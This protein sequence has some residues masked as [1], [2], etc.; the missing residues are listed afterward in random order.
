MSN[1]NKT[2]DYERPNPDDLIERIKLEDSVS[3]RGRLVIFF[4]YAAGVG[5][6]YKMLEAA[7]AQK[8]AGID[9]VI[10]FV[11][12]HGRI[13]T[14]TLMSSLECLPTSKIEYRSIQIDEFDIDAALQR[15]PKLI[16]VDE[17]AHTNTPECR[18][19][20]RWQDIEDLRDSGIDVFTTL[21]VQH[22][23][24]LNDVVAQ[25]TGVIV[26]E[27]I[28]DAVFDSADEI[29]LIDLP[30]DELLDRLKHGKV[31]LPKQI[32]RALSNFFI[33]PNLIA[34]RELA[35]RKT[36]ERINQQVQTARKSMGSEKI[37]QTGE[38]LLVCVSPN[39]LSPKVIR[40]AKRIATSLQTN[41]I[42]AHVETPHSQRISD[43]SRQ[44]LLKHLH[45][46]E[47][48]GAEIV[49][50]SGN[51]RADE[52]L[53]YAHHRNI[54]QIIVGYSDRPWWKQFFREAIS[55]ELQR[56]STDIDVLVVVGTTEKVDAADSPL[57]DVKE[58]KGYKRSLA[59]V[60]LCT[61]IAYLMHYFQLAEANKVMV[62]LLGVVFIAARYGAGPGILA[63]IVS[64]LLFD[65]LMVK[66]F[67]SF[68]V[69]D[70][71]YILTFLV[72][73][74]IAILISTLTSRIAQQSDMLRRR[75]QRTEA[76]Y[77]LSRQLASTAG[78]H[79][80]IEVADKELSEMF[81]SQIV[82][83]VR[84]GANDFTPV[85]QDSDYFTT[86][87]IEH[88]VAMWAFT[89][90]Q[91][92]GRGTDT[93]PQAKT[94][95]LPLVGTRGALGVLG[96]RPRKSNVI[97][98]PEQ[99][100]T[101]ETLSG[102]IALA[103]ERELFSDQVQKGLLDIESERLRSS[104]LSSISHDLRTPLSVISGEIQNLLGRTDLTGDHDVL[105]SLSTAAGE[106][107][108]L[109]RYIDNLLMI[110]R[111][112]A[113]SIVP[114]L[115][116]NVID[117]VIGSAISA[118]KVDLSGKEIKLNVPETP[119]VKMDSVLIERV[120]INLLDNAIKFSAPDTEIE[121]EVNSSSDMLQ[122][123]ISDRGIGM[124][125]GMEDKIFEKFYRSD[126][127]NHN[128]KL[129]T[130]LGLSIC[131]SI[132][133]MHNGSITATNRDGG[134]TIVSFRLPLTSNTE[135]TKRIND[136]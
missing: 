9:V 31:Y 13:E 113:G 7:R 111:L 96:L 134:G 95:Y 5:K 30:P 32:E 84:K 4:G 53:D 132:L 47:T 20:K 17:L 127:D 109:N 77:R 66:P 21:N 110:T 64:V 128:R 78:F 98:M 81:D 102:Q 26:Q 18:H 133:I 2:I 42:A 68:A 120:L 61:A 23:E 108:R 116:W 60:A 8:S 70:T 6:T 106:A 65:F 14:E 88:G 12:P 22:L 36:T 38:K 10:G 57:P 50:L 82:V 67:V 28:P 83:Y 43:K 136:V 103:L 56:K 125:D 16:L 62:F 74:A 126:R 121:L 73:L 135:P 94:L 130:G 48:L 33:K 76:L 34:L 117:D 86:D 80:L 29:E 52:I 58:I 79:Q 3:P 124:P 75:M 55:S 118:V 51:N 89:H 40:T 91:I 129:G 107:K 71:E 99:M 27:T 63:S 87:F 19:P 35:L 25:I 11:Q 90:V 114:D 92:T 45:L 24:T 49:T 115:Q 97:F 119:P 1:N 85:T 69:Q 105:M 39:S 122:V 123:S 101:L 37:W 46:A 100:E 112:E 54:S 44:A 59:V 72:M 131:K 15:K 41:W 104:L 93:L